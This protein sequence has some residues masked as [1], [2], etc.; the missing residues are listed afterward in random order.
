[1]N[2]GDGA[3]L[4]TYPM[5]NTI[6]FETLNERGWIK[7]EASSPPLFRFEYINNF[8]GSCSFT[9]IISPRADNSVVLD[10]SFIILQTHDIKNGD[11]AAILG[12]AKTFFNRALSRC[13]S[14]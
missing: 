2:R 13:N 7:K 1:M 5:R 12:I 9:A 11:S 8:Y 14:L 3:L 6:R 4:K 10:E